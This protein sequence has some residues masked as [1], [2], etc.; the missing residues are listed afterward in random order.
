MYFSDWGNLLSGDHAKAT[1]E[2]DNVTIQ[3]VTK[4]TSGE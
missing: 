3:Y 2:K 4:L 1:K